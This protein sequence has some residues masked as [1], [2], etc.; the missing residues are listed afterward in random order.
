MKSDLGTIQSI[1]DFAASVPF[2]TVAPGD[3]LTGSPKF[4][5]LFASLIA[6]EMIGAAAATLDKSVDYANVRAQFGHKISSYQAVAHRLANMHC[7]LEMARSALAWNCGDDSKDAQ[8]SLRAVANC[9]LRVAE[10][11]VQVHGGIGFTW[12]AA[13]HRYLRHVLG[14]NRL[15]GILLAGH[16]HGS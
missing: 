13:P 12:E 4:D 7:Q 3:P 10:D 1:D 8:S 9:C 6:S 14:L 2:A 11:A 15:L 16:D 5:A